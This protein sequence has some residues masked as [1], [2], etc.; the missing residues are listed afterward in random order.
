MLHV[1]D[2]VDENG[3]VQDIG[4]IKR[5]FLSV[6]VVVVAVGSCLG[7]FNELIIPYDVLQDNCGTICPFW[8]SRSCNGC[9]AKY[10]LLPDN[11]TYYYI[12]HCIIA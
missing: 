11:Y 10:E 3:V 6:V 1:E 7:A 4:D 2:K 12:L 5:L 8:L 9:Y